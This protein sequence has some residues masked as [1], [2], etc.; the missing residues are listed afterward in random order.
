MQPLDV[1]LRLLTDLQS[2]PLRLMPGR[3]LMAR[4][5]EADGRGRGMLNIAGALIEAELPRA[6][7]AGE[8]LRLVVRDLGEHRVTL[9]VA[10][11]EQNPTAIQTPPPIPAAIPLPGGG[12][13]RV[14]DE[15]TEEGASPAAAAGTHAIALRYDA[16][17]L[18]PL[19]LRFELDA[20][21]LR[22]TVA[23]SPGMALEQ[24]QDAATRL[25]EALAQDSER[26][27]RVSIVPRREPLDLYA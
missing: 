19:D 16:P 20:A 26:P 4:V 7:R 24:A 11:P 10:H 27:V 25:E 9:E 15:A 22:V 17:S 23:A 3:G 21:T 12:A 5:V 18:G 6:V 2:A 14:Q 1:D 13:L 8:Q